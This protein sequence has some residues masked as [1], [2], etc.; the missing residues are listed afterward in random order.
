MINLFLMGLKISYDISILGVPKRISI[1][2]KG[3]DNMCQA[4]KC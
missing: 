3:L 2:L 4:M 1:S